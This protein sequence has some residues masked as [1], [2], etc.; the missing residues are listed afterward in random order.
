[1]GLFTFGK[2]QNDA[3]SVLTGIPQDIHQ[4][5]GLELKDVL[6][7]SALQITPK[8]L[9]LGE[10][11]A[12]SFFVIAYPRFLREHWFAPIIN[13]DKVFDISIFIHP[14]NARYCFV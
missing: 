10:Q 8:E 11:I 2:T 3:S 5:G 7:P 6:A 4:A 12:R 13:L 1:M 9:L 14:M